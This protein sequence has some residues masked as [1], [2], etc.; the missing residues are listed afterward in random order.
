MHVITDAFVDPRRVE[1]FVG[2]LARHSGDGVEECFETFRARGLERS[3]ALIR[4]FRSRDTAS[5]DDRLHR[6]KRQGPAA[7][8]GDD[9]LFP[10]RNV[11]PLLVTSGLTNQ[12]KIMLFQNPDHL[13]GA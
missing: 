8:M 4:P 5:F 7:M 1:A 13:I 10:V 3:A 6:P 12:I 9:H 11:P 2:E